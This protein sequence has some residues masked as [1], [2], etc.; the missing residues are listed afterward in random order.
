VALFERTGRGVRLTDN[1]RELARSLTDSD[2]AFATHWLVSRLGRFTSEH[3]GIELVLE[4]TPRL[5]DFSKE[6]FDLGIRCGAGAWRNIEAEKI[7]DA[8]LS[9]VCNPHL[10]KTKRIRFPTDLPG[11]AL[12]REQDRA[13]WPAWLEAAGAGAIAPS[14][15]SLLVDLTTTAAEAGQGFALADRIVAADALLT[16]RLVAPF[17]VTIEPYA[18]PPGRAHVEG[19][20]RLSSV[21][22]RRNR[23]HARYAPPQA[24]WHR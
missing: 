18:A 5:V 14:G 6:D 7:A 9:V 23:P 21:D 1:G 22:Q 11:D 3:P 20:L 2:V 16:G 19:G 15:P 12:I 4:P 8:G 17:E 13:L 24:R 10:L